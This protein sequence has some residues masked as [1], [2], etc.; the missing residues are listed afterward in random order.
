MVILI[1]GYCA[2]Y[3][4][5]QTYFWLVGVWLGLFTVIAIVYFIR[6]LER[7]ERDL[8]NFLLAIEQGDFSY[9]SSIPGRENKLRG[10]YERIMAVFKRLSSEKESNH[11]L[12]QTILEHISIAIVVFD[13]KQ[14]VIVTNKATSELFGHRSFK[15]L[16]RLFDKYPELHQKVLEAVPGR[17]ILYKHIKDGTLMNLSILSSAFQL[18]GVGYTIVSFQD[19]KNE[20]EES[21]LDAWQKLIRVLTHEIMNSAIP[22]STLTS[23]I[24]KML[25]D[26]KGVQ[27]S[28]QSLTSEIIEDVVGGLSTIENRSK[29]LVRFTEAYRSLTQVGKPELQPHNISDLLQDVETLL[30][31]KLIEKKVSLTY[32]AEPKAEVMCDR[33]MIEQVLINL[34]KNAI[35]ALEGTI[36]PKISIQGKSDENIYIIEIEDN[37]P[38]IPDELIDQ[39]FIPFFSTKDSGSG[40]GLSLCKQIMRAHAGRL[41]LLS[42][43]GVGTTFRLIF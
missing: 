32:K 22:I 42:Q 8:T 23:V 3:V 24:R 40:I 30:H 14:Q 41:E 6:F 43:E 7:Q 2:A 27:L 25:L 15:Y 16:Y 9:A 33:Q 38:G 5:T 29:G 34:I 37:G 36:N 1:L 17:S 12:L 28:T 4:V 11:H 10:V 39:V 13:E 21:Q 31:P 26:E 20:L 19:I 18:N 35:E